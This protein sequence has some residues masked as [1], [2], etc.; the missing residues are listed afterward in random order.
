MREI[1]PTQLCTTYVMPNTFALAAMLLNT[2]LAAMLLN[3][4]LAAMLLNTALAVMLLN[5]ALAPMLLNTTLAAMLLNTALATMLLNTALAP[6]DPGWLLNTTLS[7]TTHTRT[8]PH[9][10]VQAVINTAQC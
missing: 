4:T 9:T 5:T 3:N 10:P 2:A 1:A 6:N 7:E 8:T